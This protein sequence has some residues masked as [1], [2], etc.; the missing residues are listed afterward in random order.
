M[1]SECEE[2]YIDA[3]KKIGQLHSIF[4]FIAFSF[5]SD[6][7]FLTISNNDDYKFYTE[8]VKNLSDAIQSILEHLDTTKT[9]PF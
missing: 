3:I 8:K 1:K 4:P 6:A 2:L 7:G 9:H 5:H